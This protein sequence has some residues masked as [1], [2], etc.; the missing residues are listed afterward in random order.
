MPR[1]KQFFGYLQEL[2]KLEK[3][4]KKKGIYQVMIDLG[5]HSP[6]TLRNWIKDR[7]IPS[8]AIDYVRGYIKGN[9]Q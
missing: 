3:I 8:I 4:I 2:E 9:K 5:Y 6:N 7:K 1:K